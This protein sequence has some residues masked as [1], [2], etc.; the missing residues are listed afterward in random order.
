MFGWKT[1]RHFIY[2]EEILEPVLSHRNTVWANFVLVHDNAHSRVRNV[3]RW[4]GEY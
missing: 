3:R 1:G 4:L 2:V